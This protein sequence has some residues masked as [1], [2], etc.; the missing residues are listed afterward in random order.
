MADRE[1]VREREREPIPESA[2]ERT[3]RHYEATKRRMEVG[4]VVIRSEDREVELTRQG[5]IK[6]Y[7]DPL[8]FKD[9]PLQHWHIFT[10]EVRTVSGKHR[11]QGGI[12][13]YVIDGRGYSVVEDDRVDWEKGDLLLLPMRPGGTDHQHFNLDPE[14]PAVWMAFIYFPIM[15]YVAH[16]ITQT[17]VAPEFKASS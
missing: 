17:Q 3:L 5:R 6:T 12:I 11:H 7:L 10:H 15:E 9:V 4:P 1:R 14:K 13:I 16:E 2:Y 8:M